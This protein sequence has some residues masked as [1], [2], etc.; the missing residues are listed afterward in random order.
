MIFSD[1]VYVTLSKKSYRNILI[2]PLYCISGGIIM[3]GISELA[4]TVSKKTNTT[5][6]VSRNVIKT[7]LNS[8]ISEADRNSKI[9]LAGFGIFERKTQKARKARNPQTKNIINVPSKK[10]FVFRA[11]SKIKYK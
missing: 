4:K 5:Q 11:S 3:V 2:L 10:K 9:N 7:F 1:A 6:K 8:V